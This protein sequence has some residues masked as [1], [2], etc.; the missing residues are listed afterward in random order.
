MSNTY[1]HFFDDRHG[2]ETLGEGTSFCETGLMAI[3]EL[4]LGFFSE[5]LLIT[6]WESFVKSKLECVIH[7]IR[8]ESWEVIVNHTK[9]R[10]RVDLNEPDPKILIDQKVETHELETIFELLR[11]QV[12]NCRN[13][14]VDDEILD[15][16]QQVILPGDLVLG[17]GQVEPGLKLGEGQ[18][19]AFLK[20]LIVVGELLV[21]VVRQ[22]HK[23]I[24]VIQGVLI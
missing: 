2:V 12:I 20:L 19:V 17:E 24:F 9:I 5:R 18:L 22:M 21:A 10:V 23:L 14:A 11:I 1:Q 4:V 6:D 13:E 7:K 16:R 15:P 3:E 8:D